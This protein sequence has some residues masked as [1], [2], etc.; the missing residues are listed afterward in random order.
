MKNATHV[1]HRVEPAGL[2]NASHAGNSTCEF[3]SAFQVSAYQVHKNPRPVTYLP[4]KAPQGMRESEWGDRIEL[5]A[6]ARIM[7]IYGFNDLAA[8]CVMKRLTDEPDTMLMN[9][10]GFF[11]EET[12]AT[13]LVKVRFGQGTPPEGL[14][15]L[16]TGEEITSKPD[17]VN[18]GCVP[19]ARA[20]FQARPDTTVIIHA[21]PH[22]VMAVSSTEAGY[23]D[24][25]RYLPPRAAMQ[26]LTVVPDSITRSRHL[27]RAAQA[28]SALAGR[29]LPLRRCRP[30]QVRLFVRGRVRGGYSTAVSGTDAH[31]P[32]RPHAPTRRPPG[33]THTNASNDRTPSV[34]ALISTWRARSRVCSCASRL[35]FA[36]GKRTVMLDHHGLYA[37]GRDAAEAWFVTFHLQQACI[38]QLKAQSTGTRLR[39]Q[40]KEHL[41]QQYQ[42]MISSPDYAYDGSREWAGCVRKLNRENPGYEA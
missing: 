39:M 27:L 4:S 40:P 9:E 18:I 36:T 33:D 35:R 1:P 28:A 8:Q 38:V 29:L 10:W 31:T 24:P 23:A 22:E 21:H 34:A 19:V 30:L 15:V 37:V 14:H 11:Y 7:S 32:T 3:C 6:L 26:G 12:T 5:S 42:E 2:T 20:I 13:S 25:P 16:P 41:E 17:L